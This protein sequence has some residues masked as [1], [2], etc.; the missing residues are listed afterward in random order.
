MVE[1]VRESVN[2]GDKNAPEGCPSAPLKPEIVSETTV[3]EDAENGVFGK[4]G[5]LAD[6]PM[7]KGK[8]D[9]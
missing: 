4:V 9:G 6:K 3:E 5:G 2:P 8:G 7:E 1:L